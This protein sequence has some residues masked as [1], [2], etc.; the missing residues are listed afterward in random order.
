MHEH[1]DQHHHGHHGHEHHEHLKNIGYAVALNFVFTIVEILGAMWTGS[2]AIFSN[3]IHDLGDTIILAFS[4]FSEK[5]ANKTTDDENYTYGLS[6]LPLLSAFISSFVLLAGSVFIL[7]TAIPRLFHPKDIHVQG[8]LLLS[9]LGVL[10]NS[11]AILRLKNNKGLNSR[12]LVLHLL[13]DVLGWV[14]VFLVSLAMNFYYIPV[15]DPVLSIAVTLYILFRVLGNLK[16]SFLLFI[17]KAPLNINVHKIKSDI[18]NMKDVH[19]ICDF[20]I[21]SLDSV[22]HIFTIHVRINQ[23]LSEKKVSSIKDKIRQI[24]KK[25][26]SFHSTIEIEYFFE[27][28]ADTC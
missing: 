16:K 1:E 26:G 13:E 19:E 3:A 21:W 2:M 8:M 22:R 24:L 10:I 4:Y 15:L 5:F 25:H 9:V 12:V 20:H 27:N 28:C 6:R 14:A 23:K 7:F 18:L 11:A 17:Q